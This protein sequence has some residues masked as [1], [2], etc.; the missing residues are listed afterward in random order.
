MTSLIENQHLFEPYKEPCFCD[1]CVGQRR[2]WV[3]KIL[4]QLENT[5]TVPDNSN[6]GQ[7]NPSLFD[8]PLRKEFLTFDQMAEFFGLSKKWLRQQMAAG[9]LPYRSYGRSGV[10]F[11][12]PDVRQAILDG[13]LAPTSK[14]QHDHK[15][16]N[17]IR[18]Q[19]SGPCEGEGFSSIQE[20]RHLQR[21]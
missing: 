9:K 2:D 4:D 18:R 13:S 14:V 21:S 11:Y 12:V 5:L 17:K 20:L 16:K 6:S 15:T 7:L 10:L 8:N 1:Q 3:T 19:V